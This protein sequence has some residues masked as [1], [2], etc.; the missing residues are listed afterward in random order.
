MA[1]DAPPH[2]A[3]TSA[4][5]ESLPC[6]DLSPLFPD[7]ESEELADALSNLFQSIT[8]LAS[9]YDELGVHG[10]AAPPIDDGFIEK[11]ERAVNGIND[12]EQS[13][14]SIS[15]YL[16]GQVSTD[17]R[18]DTA[19][20]RLSELMIRRV[21]LSTLQT[22]LTD[23][24]G[25]LPL[26]EILSRSALAANHGHPLRWRHEY[27]QHLMSEEA[28]ALAAELSPSSA[29]AW[30]KLHGDL[31]SQITATIDLG[32]AMRTMPMS[33]LRNLAMDPRREIRQHA[34]E[35]ELSA[36]EANAL[37]L[38]A[39]IN[40]VKGQT[41]V[42]GGRR[43]WADPLDEALFLNAIDRQV[44]DAMIG[45][46]RAAFPDFRRY[47]RLKAKA[48]GVPRLAWYDLF[49]PVGRAERAWRWDEATSF[50]EASFATFSERM[51]SL[52]RRSVAENWIDAGPRPGKIGGAYCMWLIDDQ[53][54]ILANYSPSYDGVSTLAHE[55]GHAYHNLNETGLTPMQ[56]QTPM[57]LAETASTFCE[58][59]VKEAALAAA[60][61]GERRYILEQWL[62]GACQIVVDIVSRFD[63]ESALFARRRDRELSIG[64]LNQLMLD[65]QD[66]T[67]GDGLDPNARHPYMW[68]VKGH[69][70]RTDE[71]FYN[72]P[73]L[74][75]L[76]FGL[77][78]YTVYQREPGSFPER[79]DAL[80]ASTGRASAAEL[81]AGFD[82]DLRSPA[83]WRMSLDLL[84]A[85]IDRFEAL[86]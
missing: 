74:F 18:N 72:F 51:A 10:A 68:A 70:Y 65:A 21:A 11:F 5:A 1:H 52:A 63:F 56:R 73:Y 2:A 64:E 83:F 47:L 53:S 78:L 75:G 50:I 76:L 34:W 84:R 61:A 25:A 8:T 24:I 22:R 85:D 23:W 43:N 28:E 58:T 26:D 6:W 46:A 29:T 77:G 44:L 60:P 15:A 69:Y 42:L 80:L 14:S 40:G 31:T 20:A 37:P 59:I 79:Y 71:S 48:L 13:F 12:V 45:E 38:A 3:E 4:E 27:A 32:G 86:I 49:A 7:L 62:Q 66:G 33:E 19:Q 35:V 30:N 17:S 81:A 67:Y 39:A 36:W 82:I 41:I 55:L 57:I 9:L 16:Y 54:R